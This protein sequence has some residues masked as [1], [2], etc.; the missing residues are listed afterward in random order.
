LAGLIEYLKEADQALFLLLNGWNHPAM[1]GFF[2]FLSAKLVWAPL[3][4]YLLFL[5][6]K[7]VGTV[8]LLKTVSLIVAMISLSD[9]LASGLFKPFFERLRPCYEPTLEGMV[10]FPNGCGGKH[11]FASSHASNTFAAASFVYLIFRKTNSLIFL[12]LIWAVLVSY[13]RIYLG[14][15]YPGDIIVGACL[16]ILSAA[17]AFRVFK[18]WIA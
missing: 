9:F 3:Y 10:Y 14:V 4:A 7:K 13:S 15:H 18:R 12:L 16:G 1:D 17:L 8:G 11:G 2:I 5:I 6:W